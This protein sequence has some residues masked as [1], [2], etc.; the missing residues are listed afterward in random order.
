MLGIEAL[1][2][3]LAPL[4]VVA[5]AAGSGASV[6]LA[7]G[8]ATSTSGGAAAPTREIVLKRG[9]RGPAVRRVQDRLRIEVDGYFGRGTELSVK[10]FQ[11][12]RGLEAD[13]VVG[14]ATRRALHLRPFTRASVLRASRVRLPRALIRIAECESGG[15]PRAVSRDGRYRGKYQFTLATWRSLGG[16]GDPARASEALQDRL[17][18][19]LYRKRG[20]APWPRCA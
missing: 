12:S 18:L 11:R 4:M 6:A 8:A 20:T 10:R 7:D 9:D 19:R 16:S 15:N 1:R 17:A 3:A 14:P 2:R 5:V 13:G